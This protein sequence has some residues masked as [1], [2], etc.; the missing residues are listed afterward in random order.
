V[1]SSFVWV[2]RLRRWARD[3]E[4]LRLGGPLDGGLCEL[5]EV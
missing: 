3:S 4:R 5:A 1:R 2:V